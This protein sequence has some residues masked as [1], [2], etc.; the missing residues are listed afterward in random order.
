MVEVQMDFILLSRLQFAAATIFHFIFVPL[1]LGL[2]L[3]LAIME[4]RYVRT[5]DEVYLSMAEFWGKIFLINFGMGVVTGLTLEFQFGTNW[6]AFS[7]FVGGIFGPILAFETTSAFFVESIFLGIWIFGWKKVSKTFHAA[8]MWIVFIASTFSAY[9]IIVAN[10]WMQHPVGFAI[11]N[12]KAALISLSK[13]LLNEFAILQI[14]HVQAAAFLLSAFFVMSVSAY[15]LLKKQ[16]VAFFEKS[17]KMALILGLL[18][19]IFVAAEGDFHGAD[20]A[21]KQPAKMAAMESLWETMPRAPVYL[22][23]WPDEENERNRIE[24]GAIP[25]LLS[26][27]A[28]KDFDATVQGL[29]EFPKDERPNVL[30][31]SLSFKGMVA[32]GTLF[33][34]LTMWGWIRRN[35][36]TESTLFLK[37]MLFSVPLPYIANE[38]GWILTEAGR[39]PWV[40]YGLLKTSDAASILA[41]SQVWVTLV[42]FIAGYGI[43]GA[44]AFYLMIRHI[45]KGPEKS[46]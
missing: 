2:S 6:G 22:F 44:L 36:L 37:V 46:V 34:G 3:L 17:F 40:A 23:A 7:V 35:R 33:I 38:L 19:S 12:G 11:R 20:V 8:C 26:F 21:E 39:Q 25:G 24:I 14:L 30:I 13:V 27:L 4:T 41:S 10:A 1:T 18:S 43:L 29:K 42:I 32:L 5:G 9:W 45:Q 16:H 31:T 28:F 15:Y